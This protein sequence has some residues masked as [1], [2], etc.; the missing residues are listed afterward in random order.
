MWFI[1]GLAQDVKKMS[2]GIADISR[3][4][5]VQEQILK[6]HEDQFN[7]LLTILEQHDVR[8]RV[9]ENLQHVAPSATVPVRQD[10]HARQ[11]TPPAQA[12]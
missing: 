3:S 5:A 6:Q 7:R 12:R 9:L 2:T 8:L 4:T 11:Q 10:Y 1:R